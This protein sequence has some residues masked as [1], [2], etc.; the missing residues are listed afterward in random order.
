ML[1]HGQRGL[2]PGRVRCRVGERSVIIVAVSTTNSSSEGPTIAEPS[3][4]RQPVR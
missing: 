4:F 2:G 3:G 1:A